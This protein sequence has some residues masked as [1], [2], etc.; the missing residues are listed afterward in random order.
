M[1]VKEIFEKMGDSWDHTHLKS[2]G[3]RTVVGDNVRKD[4]SAYPKLTF[5]LSCDKK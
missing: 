5:N 3:S 1:G 4:I 2:L